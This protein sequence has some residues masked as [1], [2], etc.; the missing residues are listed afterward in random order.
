MKLPAAVIA[1]AA[2]LP[3]S[4]RQKRTPVGIQASE[5]AQ[6]EATQHPTRVQH[7][8]AVRPAPAAPAMLQ[9]AAAK[10]KTGYTSG[11]CQRPALAE[12]TR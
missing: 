10:I 1:T 4:F 12:P 7:T 11:T 5:C 2:C 6:P 3:A 8:Q 9:A